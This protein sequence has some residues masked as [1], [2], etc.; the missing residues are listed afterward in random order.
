MKKYRFDIKMQFSGIIVAQ[1]RI[2]AAYIAA[3][4]TNGCHISPHFLRG[5]NDETRD[6]HVVEAELHRDEDVAFVEE[7]QS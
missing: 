6:A 1:N 5:F 3:K 7:E 2:A 4:L